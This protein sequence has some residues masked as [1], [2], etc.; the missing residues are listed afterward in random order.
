MSSNYQCQMPRSAYKWLIKR[1]LNLGY[2]TSNITFEDE[3]A[4]LKSCKLT[5]AYRPY[6]SYYPLNVVNKDI[7]IR[8]INPTTEVVMDGIT[9]VQDPWYPYQIE[10]LIFNG[11][12]TIVFWDDGTKTVVK[13]K[14][15]S[16][17]SSNDH[18]IALMW[19]MAKKFIG[20]RSQLE[21][22]LK[23]ARANKAKNDNGTVYTI[24]MTIFDD[25]KNL[26]AYISEALEHAIVK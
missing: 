18:R 16:K 14:E 23:Y 17:K 25:P 3:N 10:K 11:P 13:L 15:G 20:S 12:A 4:F 8:P 9:F 19:A 26:E 1:I 22:R 7:F 21:K 5:M 2:G 24:L 6:E